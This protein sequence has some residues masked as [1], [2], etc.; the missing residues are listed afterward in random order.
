MKSIKLFLHLFCIVTLF[1]CNKKVEV[2]KNQKLN[3]LFIMTDDLNCDLGSYR[4]I[5]R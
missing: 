1:G 3:V 2:D 5:L 4:I